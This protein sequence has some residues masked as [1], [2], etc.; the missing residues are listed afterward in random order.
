MLTHTLAKTAQTTK[1]LAF[2]VVYSAM[3]ISKDSRSDL[4]LPTEYQG[5]PKSLRREGKVLSSMCTKENG[6]KR[7]SHTR[8]ILF[9]PFIY[10]FFPNK[11]LSFFNSSVPKLVVSQ[12]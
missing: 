8:V 11:S 10:E 12:P 6:K 4:S 3:G 9:L 2:W 5:C 7:E 1:V